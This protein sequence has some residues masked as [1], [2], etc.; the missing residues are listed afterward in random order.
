[1]QPLWDNLKLIKNTFSDRDKEYKQL[2]AMVEKEKIVITPLAY[3]RGRSLADIIFIVDESQT[4]LR[5]R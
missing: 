1:M 5:T 2:E 4:S 3:I